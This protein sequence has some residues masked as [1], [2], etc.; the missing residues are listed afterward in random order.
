MTTTA[1]YRTAALAASAALD[2]KAAAD[3]YQ[4]AIDAYPTTPGK[5]LGALALRDIEAMQQQRAA[6]LVMAREEIE[7]QD[8]IAA[9]SEIEG[10]EDYEFHGGNRDYDHHDER[11]YGRDFRDDLSPGEQAMCDRLD[12]GRNDAGEW[13]GFC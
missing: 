10:D 13:I 2:W 11:S 7:R 4:Q 3:L 5:G 9:A 12:M 1:T 8:A 6:C